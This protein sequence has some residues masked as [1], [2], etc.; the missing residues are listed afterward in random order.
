MEFYYHEIYKDILILAADGGISRENAGEFVDQLETLIDAGLT[1]IIVD[2]SKLEFISTVG[3]S[4]LLRL[5]NRLKEHGG[6]IKLAGVHSPIVSI[7]TVA[8]LDHLFNIYADVPAAL[9]AFRPSTADDRAG[10]TSAAR[11]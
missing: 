2:C 5:H 9:L 6:Q 3:L 4:T 8:R 7:L 10:G 1:R 11:A